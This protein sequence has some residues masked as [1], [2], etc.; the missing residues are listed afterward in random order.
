MLFPV[1]LLR[2][3]SY[4]HIYWSKLPVFVPVSDKCQIPPSFGIQLLGTEHHVSRFYIFSKS[5]LQAYWPSKKG[6]RLSILTVVLNLGTKGS[7]WIW[8]VSGAIYNFTRSQYG[9]LFSP[10]TLSFWLVETIQE[11]Y[12][13]SYS[14][15]HL[16]HKIVP[17]YMNS[18]LPC[19]DHFHLKNS[20]WMVFGN[21]LWFKG[22]E[23][24]LSYES[25]FISLI[26]Y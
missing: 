19:I 16:L 1:F 11:S 14:V 18:A 2:P 25:T 9:L 24:C 3:K 4:T 8:L 21:L 17:S 5:S 22:S 12:F 7:K 15:G 13:C 26:S 6:T 10:T 20:I 23:R